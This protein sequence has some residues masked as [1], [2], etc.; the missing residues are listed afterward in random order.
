MNELLANL[1]VSSDSVNICVGLAT[2]TTGLLGYLAKV[3][4]D[5][6]RKLTE[7]EIRLVVLETKIGDRK[8]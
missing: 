5:I 3:G 8:A 4:R 7:M 2:V 6:S 1:T